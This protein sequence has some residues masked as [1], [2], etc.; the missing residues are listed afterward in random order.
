MTRRWAPRSPA[1][2]SPRRSRSAPGGDGT[3]GASVAGEL[4]PPENEIPPGGGGGLFGGLARQR[5]PRG[6]L[7]GLAEARA[8][9]LG[10]T[11]TP[12]WAD[13]RGQRNIDPEHYRRVVD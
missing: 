2:S 12:P 3:A 6:R 9:A 11:G 13:F 5:D 4:N 8:I 7:F 1:S 10:G